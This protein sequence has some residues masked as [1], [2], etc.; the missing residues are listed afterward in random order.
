VEQKIKTAP[1]FT[2]DREHGLKLTGVAHVAGNNDL[3]PEPLGERAHKRFSSCVPIGNGKFRASAAKY[4]GAAIGYAV[5]V[6]DADDQTPL[7]SKRH[8]FLRT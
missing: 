1:F 8:N 7:T 5:L 6:G 3:A 4:F 2:D